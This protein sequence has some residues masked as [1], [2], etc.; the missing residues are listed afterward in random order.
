VDNIQ[1]SPR[2]TVSGPLAAADEVLFSVRDP[3][4]SL[5]GVALAHELA[6][7]RRIP[8]E[9]RDRRFELRLP[10]PPADR[11]EYLLELQHRNGR[12][13]IVPDPGNP[14]QAPGPFGPKSVIE[15]PGYE[16]PAWLADED[17]EPGAV[18]QVELPGRLPLGA[19]LWSAADADPDEPLPLLLVHDGPE[20]VEYSALLRLLDHLVAFGELPP[21]RAALLPPPLDRNETY[22]ASA[23]YARALVED[24]LPALEPFQGR[25]VG[26]GASLGA[27]AML[28]A[29]WTNP[30]VL[31]GLFLQSGSY[32]RRRLDPQESGTPRFARITRFVSSVVGGRVSVEPVPAALT[33]GTAEENLGNN[34][35]LAAA[36]RRDGWQAPLVEH[37]D[38]H[39][40]VSWRD[41]FHPHL[42]E[43]VL[44]AIA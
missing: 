24:W 26:M 32:F 36:L 43:L 37:P 21:L 9:R 22:S 42:A 27:L 8:F 14:L 29:H 15:F 38:A 4:G 25:P 23:R 33:C 30:G 16:P 40:W 20:Y 35:L 12:S 3:R 10:R 39:N 44:R 6:R 31:G 28:H 17:S 11:L 18:R 1:L 19:P 2:G 5:V 7:P 34:R 13:E 41:A